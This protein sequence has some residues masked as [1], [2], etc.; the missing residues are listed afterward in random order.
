MI[1]FWVRSR[2]TADA[3]MIR[4]DRAH[5]VGLV[6]NHGRVTFSAFDYSAVS[7]ELQSGLIHYPATSPPRLE[8]SWQTV[9]QITPYPAYFLVVPHA[10]VAVTAG[11][12][13]VGLALTVW[14]RFSLQ[15]LLMAT[16]FIAIMLGLA[17]IMLRES[18]GW[19][20]VGVVSN[21]YT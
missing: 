7:P 16:T 10:G 14:R 5:G 20:N 8:A 4:I 9:S 17:V 15:A 18:R 11:L 13:A 2:E 19:N 3:L 6:S 12:L 21:R 1:V